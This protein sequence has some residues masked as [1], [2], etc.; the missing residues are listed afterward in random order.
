M[1]T[2]SSLV[3]VQ[4]SD[5]GE[6]NYQGLTLKQSV[7]L[8]E[9]LRSCWKEDVL[10]LS[11]SDRFLRLSLQLLSRS[12][13]SGMLRICVVFLVLTEQK[14]TSLWSCRYSSWLS[15][16][17]TARKNHNTSTGS[18]SEWAVSAVIDDFIFVCIV[19]SLLF[20]CQ[21]VMH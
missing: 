20:L 7:T 12:V 17:L 9:S 8:L 15:S 6:K 2:T 19:P 18:G 5:A 13:K 11:C 10:V 14:L 21:A 16:G 3:P 1:L 4:N